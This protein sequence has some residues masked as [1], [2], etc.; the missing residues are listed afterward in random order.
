MLVNRRLALQ[1]GVAPFVCMLLLMCTPPAAAQD[2][3]RGYVQAIAG[4][5][6]TT[7]TD[8][9]VGG[10]AAFRLS[11]RIEAFGELGRMRNG[12][13]KA[14]DTELS[15]AGDAIRSEIEFQFGTDSLVEFEARVPVVYGLGGARLR[16]PRFGRLGTHAEAAIGLARLRPEVQLTING[17]ELGDEAGR[18]LTLDAERSEFLSAVGAGVSFTLL[19]FVRVEGGYRFSRIHGDLP[20]NVNRVHVGIG[21]AF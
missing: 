17:E 21:Y 7:V 15:A 19:R 10:G 13:W 2:A 14:L 6:S 12:I 5:A 9:L 16:G 1:T 18:L 20:V 11:D 8:S 4:A 3:P